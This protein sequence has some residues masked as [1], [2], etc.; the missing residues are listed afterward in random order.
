ML[1]EIFKPGTYNHPSGDVSYNEEDC[2]QI[3][4][5]YNSRSSNELAPL[6]KGHPYTDSPAFGWI[7][8]LKFSG[9]ILFAKLKD[10]TNEIIEDI[11]SKKF[12]K[13][14]VA[15]RDKFHL[16]HVGLLGAVE[17]KVKGL[18]T[19]TLSED[20]NITS[21]IYGSS[22][23]LESLERELKVYRDRDNYNLLSSQLET[24]VS[25]GKLL[26][27]SKSK[28]MDLY[29]ACILTLPH[30]KSVEFVNETLKNFFLEKSFFSSME[31]N[32]SGVLTF[33][34]DETPEDLHVKIQSVAKAKNIDYISAFNF[35]INSRKV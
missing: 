35:L 30:D 31:F 9:G 33:S 21:L 20:E 7:E 25:E 5:D 34:G 26:P 3:A 23:E 17:P 27:V 28:L 6:V 24:Y 15:L 18:E 12:Q 10:L 4:D 16:V 8:K 2:Q 32:S 14:S 1:V 11:K 13:I 29:S 22:E 19:V